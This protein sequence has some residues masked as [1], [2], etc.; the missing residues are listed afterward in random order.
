M[1]GLKRLKNDL[2]EIELCPEDGSIINMKKDK[3][4]TLVKT[5]IRQAAYN[6]MTKIK[7]SHSKVKHIKYPKYEIQLCLLDIT[8]STKVID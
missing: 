7:E 4:K 2:D 1:I 5:K 3:F 8:V 6:Y